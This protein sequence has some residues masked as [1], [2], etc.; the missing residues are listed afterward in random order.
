MP[1]SFLNSSINRAIGSA[2]RL[3]FGVKAP[4]I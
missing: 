3:V 1:G 2:N 4:A